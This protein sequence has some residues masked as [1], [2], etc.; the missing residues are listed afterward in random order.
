MGIRHIAGPKEWGAYQQA[1][2]V[3]ELRDDEGLEFVQIA[4]MLGTSSIEASRRYRAIAALKAMEQDEHFAKKADPTF[5]R[6]FHKMV[7]LPEVRTRFGWSNE[8][9]SFFDIE[10]GRLFFDLLV[11]GKNHDAKIKTY[12]D[13]RKLKFVVGNL[14]AED[15]LWDHSLPLSEAIRI[16]EQGKKPV[17]ASGLLA[18]AK[19][20]LSQ[21][22]VMHASGLKAK[23]ARCIAEMITMLGSLQKLIPA[24]K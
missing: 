17:D 9:V 12:Q 6:L 23:D 10:K 20:S 8:T 22:G 1:I 24:K 15:A 4:E 5:Y 18:E 11:E 13:V 14:K 7:S 19:E 21:I 2:L 16:G 3:S